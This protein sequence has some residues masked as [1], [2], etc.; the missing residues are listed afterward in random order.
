MTIAQI[1]LGIRLR[2]P[3]SFGTVDT[4]KGFSIAAQTVHMSVRIR[5]DLQTIGLDFKARHVATQKI[6]AFKGERPPFDLG[7]A[8]NGHDAQW[9]LL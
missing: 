5:S 9:V 3:L 6:H 7:L 2:P 8:P 1:F 4:S